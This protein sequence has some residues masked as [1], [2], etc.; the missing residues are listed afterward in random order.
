MERTLPALNLLPIIGRR[1]IG[2][3]IFA[4]FTIYVV[5]VL[6]W[7]RPIGLLAL[8]GAWVAVA[9]ANNRVGII[10]IIGTSAF[11]QLAHFGVVYADQIDVS[12]AALDRILTGQSPYG[13]LYE[14]AVGGVN[15]YPYGPLAL[16]TSVGGWPLEFAASVGILGLL[17]WQRAWITL[18]IMAAGPM[19]LGS[20]IGAND[21]LPALVLGFGLVQLRERPRSG[22]ILLALAAAIKPHAGAWFLP[23]I[24]YAGWSAGAW[25]IGT[26]A[27][28]WSPV[29]F[30][31]IGSFLESARIMYGT[32]EPSKLPS[33]GLNVPIIRLLA[34]P[35]AVAGLLVRRWDHMLLVGAV[36]YMMVMFFGSWAHWGYAVA[37]VMAAGLAL[38]NRISWQPA[39]PSTR[40]RTPLTAR[41][42]SLR[43]TH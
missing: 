43:S 36:V 27:I 42:R 24:G 2:S 12:R 10:A 15:G 6:A 20:T 18:G 8:F 38:E 31:G 41:L 23:A 5:S 25:L 32:G 7:G 28:L 17:A 3:L 26:S 4:G 22:M 19:T 9:F 33:L 37:P 40:S 13:V 35:V 11:L 14:N 30:W 21:W 39:R 34:A 29:L 1:R 16:V